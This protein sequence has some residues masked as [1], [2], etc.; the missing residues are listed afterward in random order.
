MKNTSINLPL[1]LLLSR[2]I[3]RKRKERIHSLHGRKFERSIAYEDQC[4]FPELAINLYNGSGITIVLEL[5]RLF[6]ARV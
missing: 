3:K 1:S 2:E 4:F 6:N 5:L